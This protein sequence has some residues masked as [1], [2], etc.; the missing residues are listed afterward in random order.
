MSRI[1]KVSLCG[2]FTAL[3]LIS[4]MIENLFPSA[5]IPGARL[6]ISNVFILLSLIFLG[7]PWAFSSLIIKC[8]LGSV[9]SGNVSAVIYSLPA[10]LIA[11]S[12]ETVLLIF[13]KDI[14][15][16]A[17][18]VAGAVINSLMQTVTFALVTN[19]I[20]MFSYLPY[21]LL[22]GTGSGVIVGLLV[23]F[24]VKTMPKGVK[25]DLS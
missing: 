13:T 4:F 8:V 2:I 1:K 22:I 21:L 23:F 3:A 12:I 18:S 15:V 14:S 20:Y 10:G 17:I 24:T 9:F 19:S 11:L 7:V 6:G 16:V 5:L 25:G